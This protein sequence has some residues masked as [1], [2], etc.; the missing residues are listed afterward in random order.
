MVSQLE[1]LTNS[2]IIYPKTDG[3][4]RVNNTNF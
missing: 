3:Q 4:P 1:S 2:E